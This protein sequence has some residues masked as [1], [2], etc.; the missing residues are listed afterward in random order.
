MARNRPAEEAV[1]MEYETIILDRH[2]GVALLTLNRPHVLNAVNGAMFREFKE[3]LTEIEEDDSIRVLVLTGAGRGFCSSV[4][5]KEERQVRI[6]LDHP[7]TLEDIR[8]FLLRYPQWI[9]KKLYS[10]EKPTIAMLNGLAVADAVDW[11]LACDIRTG[12]ENTRIANGFVK[13][14]AFPNTGATWL[15]PRVMGLGRALEF[16]Y[17]GDWMEAQELY[18]LG[19]LNH[20]YPA[21]ELERETMALAQRIADGP[22]ISIRLMKTY[23]YKNL[24]MNLDTAL[25]LAADGE[26]MTLFTEDHKEAVA[27]IKGKRKPVFQGK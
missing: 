3:A 21:E 8:R 4:D 16:M 22:A 14:A 25:E 9:T 1:L 11:A 17:T 6:G 2:D 13:N 12:S 19:V 10:M 26:A 5:L 15:Y 23:T 7:P 27:A 24:D 20:I 18:G